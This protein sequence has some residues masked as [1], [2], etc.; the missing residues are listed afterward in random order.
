MSTT[1]PSKYAENQFLAG[2]AGSYPLMSE[3]LADTLPRATTATTGNSDFAS[4]LR[5]LQDVATAWNDGESAIA[6]SDAALP[7]ATY[8]FSDK[9]ASL[10]RKPD[11]DTNSPLESWDT[12]IRGAVAYQGPAYMTLLPQGR[13][14]LTNGTL[15]QQLDAIR[16]F[17]VR[18]TAQTT[19]P[20]LVTLGTTVTGFHTAAHALRTSQTNAK[21]ALETAREAQ[22]GRR[23]TAAAV[24][25]ALIGQGM[26]S[27]RTNPAQV[28]TLW[29]VNI[30][31]NPPLQIPE[32]PP[33]IVWTPA[34]RTL[35]TTALPPGATRLE[36]WRVGPGGRPELLHTGLPGET[37][38]IIPAAITFI[39]GT[40]YQLWLNALNGKGR[41]APG[42]VQSWTAA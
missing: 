37:A 7:A 20:A 1:S 34:V 8:A 28:D 30:L 38:L 15:D 32:A 12:T 29:D 26:V 17:G 40:L 39:P 24:L 22:E 25:Y 23:V 16:N 3:F 19:K 5:D 4:V 9:M 21:A 10:T 42:P 36:A 18:L 11:A 35:S 2:T 31:R 27:W 33:D 14:T 13:E 41:S 6:N